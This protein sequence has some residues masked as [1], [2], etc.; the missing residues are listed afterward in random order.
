MQRDERRGGKRRSPEKFRRGSKE[1]APKLYF[2]IHV[3]G[4]TMQIDKAEFHPEE[5]EHGAEET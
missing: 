2:D 3:P 5:R 4:D 1:K